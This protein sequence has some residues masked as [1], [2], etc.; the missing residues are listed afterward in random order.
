V[1]RIAPW[2]V[3]LLAATLAGP[4]AGA[5][6]LVGELPRKDERPLE[7]LPG[8]DTEHGELR[9]GEARLRTYVTRPEGHTGRLPAVLFVQW[10]S[11]DTIE[12]KADAKDGWS[13]MLRRLMTESGALW[14]RTDKSGV[15][16]SRGVACDKL[17]YETELSYHRAALAAL[18]ARTDVDPKRVV[19]YGASMGSN[20]APLVAADQPVAGV[21]VWGGGAVTWYERMLRFERNALELGDTPPE[22]LT[23]EVN[24]R[25]RYFARYLLGGES[26]DA[27]A[28]SNPEL[29]KVWARI[30]GTSAEGH[31]GRPFAFHQQAQRQ[32]WAG[33]WARVE[34][35]VLALYG[36]YDW[37]ESRDAAALIADVVNRA[38]PGTAEF[39]VLPATDHHFT[40]FASRRDAFKDQG[41]KTDA[42]PAV[43][44]ILGW[45]RA[46]GLS[47]TK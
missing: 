3:A 44:A 34:A 6:R 46:R 8:L 15:G 28:N 35:P 16:D 10:L 37:F 32:D 27:I 4:A 23:S 39:R 1:I 47:P 26:P 18:R 31:Y 14:M 24:A 41:G 12:Q 30:V 22:K 7:A 2:L 13:V 11:C 5:S 45:L 17:D 42:G 20:Y 40:R 43:D 9:V 21:V 36:E 33:A 29:G 38:R 19:V 25:A